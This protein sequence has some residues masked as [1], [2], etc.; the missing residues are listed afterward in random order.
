MQVQRI[1]NQMNNFTGVK[2]KYNRL[3]DITG[4]HKEIY[5]SEIPQFI[6]DFKALE[7][8]GKA[9]AFEASSDNVLIDMTCGSYKLLFFLDG[10]HYLQFKG[11]KSL[12][13][14]T[15]FLNK[16]GEK[17]FVFFESIKEIKPINIE[18]VLRI[19]YT[20]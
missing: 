16:L 5:R 17:L 2:V 10:K 19:N 12:E 6:K 15:K 7:T 9:M 8:K 4:E 18:D 20:G 1:S 13:E 11:L 14:K 3:W